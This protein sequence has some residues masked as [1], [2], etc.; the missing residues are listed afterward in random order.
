MGGPETPGGPTQK[1]KEEMPT[2]NKRHV[3]A[4]LAL[5]G[6]FLGGDVAR[7]LSAITGTEPVAQLHQADQAQAEKLERVEKQLIALETR[8]EERY[9]ALQDRLTRIETHMDRRAE[10]GIDRAT[11]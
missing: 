10:K 3:L 4:L 1:G 7:P 11:D 5:I 9:L 6:T 8:E 2:I